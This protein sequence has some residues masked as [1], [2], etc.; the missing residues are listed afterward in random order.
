MLKRYIDCDGVILDTERDLFKEYE[1]QKPYYTNLT[2]E[3]YLREL[4]WYEWLRQAGDI[5]DGIYIL[6]S[7]D[8]TCADILTTVHSLEEGIEK[9]KYFRELDLK[10]NIILVPYN[11]RKDLIVDAKGFVLVDNYKANLDSWFN[12]EGLPVLFTKEDAIPNIGDYYQINSLTEAFDPKL[13][14]KIREYQARL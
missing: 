12:K 5:N 8:P 2:K 11:L 13:D 6:K 4:D 10:N 7:N 1:R 9:V 3:K 14:D